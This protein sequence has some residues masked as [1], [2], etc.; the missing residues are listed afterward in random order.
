M[1]EIGFAVSMNY[2]KIRSSYFNQE[3][4]FEE[5]NRIVSEFKT[6][7]TG[8]DCEYEVILITSNPD[9]K[10]FVRFF[11]S[12]TEAMNIKLKRKE[13]GSLTYE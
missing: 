8:I 7:F 2:D 5:I 6:D 13:I 11:V 1:K 10:L 12:K 4:I 9:K 3:S